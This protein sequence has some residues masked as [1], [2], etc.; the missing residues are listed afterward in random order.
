NSFSGFWSLPNSIYNSTLSEL[1]GAVLD[2]PNSGEVLSG[3]EVSGA[4]D[5]TQ[6]QNANMTVVGG[7]TLNGKLML[8]GNV[9]PDLGDSLSRTDCGPVIFHAS[10]GNGLELV[11]GAGLLTIC[12]ARSVQGMSGLLHHCSSNFNTAEVLVVISALDP[13]AAEGHHV[14]SYLQLV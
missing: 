10:A 5:L 8:G 7:L 6:Q 2:L 13:S 9:L 1:V 12:P 3:M 11:D 4:L 14:F